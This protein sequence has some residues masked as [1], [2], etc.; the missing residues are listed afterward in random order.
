MAFRL[1]RETREPLYRQIRRAI[2]ERIARNS[3]GFDH[4][5]PSTRGLAL[6]LGVSRNTVN[7]A[8]QELMAE[9]FIVSHPRRG[10]FVN[11]ELRPERLEPAPDSSMPRSPRWL[12]R[13]SASADAGLPKIQKVPNWYRY[14]YVFIAGQVDTRTFP[15]RAWLR[16]L[17][18][19]LDEPHRHFS[20]CDAVEED[21]PMLVEMLCQEILPPRGIDARPEEVLVTLGSQE[22]LALLQRVLLEPGS[23][24][25]VEDPGYLDARHIFWRAGA[26]LRPLPVDGSGVIPP[27]DLGGAD[28]LY[29]TP[30]HHHPTNATLS[31]GRRRQLLTQAGLTDTVIIED[32]Y[33]SELRYQGA[34]SPALKGLDEQGR[35]VY[36]GTFSKFL[37]PGLRL[38]YVVGNPELISRLR[39]ERRYSIRHP[40]GHIQ[41]AMALL[42]LSGQYHRAVR[43]HRSILKRKWEV[44][45]EAVG[46]DLDWGIPLPPGGVSIWVQGPPE[47]DAT[48]LAEHLL[49][50]SVI[51]E[52]GDILFSDP[53]LHRNCFRLG[54]AASQL[55]AIR[56]GIRIVARAANRQLG[57]SRDPA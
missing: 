20:L 2:E 30:S 10:L 37:A 45:C 53:S 7:L 22:G 3:F 47:L 15:S 41:R 29:L 5:L 39:D 48:T 33:D 16:A 50:E 44:I 31:I 42:I 35:V 6:E 55:E 12:A 49:R 38:G 32:D 14:K 13:H 23:L 56:P 51:I 46:Q 43:Q 19:A 17:G 8:Y 18:D 57:R 52:R 24:V 11:E 1:E 4:P 9:G 40:P 34:P 54:F 28:L 21:D 25:A 36:L 27:P 26:T